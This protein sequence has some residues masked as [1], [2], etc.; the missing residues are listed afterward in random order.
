MNK[1][2]LIAAVGSIL[3]ACSKSPDSASN[4]NN[5]SSSNNNVVDCTGTAKSFSLNVNPT[6][7]STCAI[8]SNCHAAGSNN[9]PGELLNYNE[10]ERAS[11]DIRAAIISGIMP[12]T[13]SLSASQKNSI[14]CWIDNGSANN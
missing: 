4:S 7:Q 6:I 8:G 11:A 9:G 10:V 12:K 13:G 5:S 2:L 3:Y 1:F 14:I